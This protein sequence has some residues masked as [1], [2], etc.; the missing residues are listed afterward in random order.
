MNLKLRH[1]QDTSCLMLRTRTDHYRERSSASIGNARLRAGAE[2]VGREL[3]DRRMGAV[4][5]GIASGSDANG[6]LAV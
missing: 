1:D 4:A 2:I 6:A 3:A 5:V